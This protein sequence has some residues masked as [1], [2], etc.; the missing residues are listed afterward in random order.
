M[1]R[2]VSPW[3]IGNRV[4]KQPFYELMPGGQV[5]GRHEREGQEALTVARAVQSTRGPCQMQRLRRT[6]A[7]TQGGT[8]R[9]T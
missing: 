2:F 5:P 8:C 4:Y 3:A 9:L 6:I 7:G 1:L